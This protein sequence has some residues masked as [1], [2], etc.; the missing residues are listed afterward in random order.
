MADILPIAPHRQKAF[1]KVVVGGEDVTAKINER[2]LS[3][4]II[5]K[6]GGMDEC[7]LEL[8]DREGRIRLPAGPDEISV[9]L[10]WPNEGSFT[11]FKGK[12]ADLW[13][14]GQKHGGRTLTISAMGAD[15]QKDTKAP[16]Q[17]SL[18]DGQEDVKIGD[19]MKK[20][21]ELAGV[22]IKVS[23][24][25]A[26]LARKFWMGNNES[27]MAFA[28]RI[29]GEVGGSFKISGSQ[30]T[31]TKAGS[32]ANADGEPLFEV[33][34]KA[35]KN[36][37]AWRICPQDARPQ[38]GGTGHTFFNPVLAKW[39]KVT[40]AIKG[41]GL[42]G[43]AAS[44]M[45]TGLGALADKDVA[46]QQA[47]GD[48]TISLGMRGT[49]WVALDGEPRAVA[50]GKIMIIGARPGVDGDYHM[51]EVEH[52]MDAQTGFTTRCDVSKLGA[53]DSQEIK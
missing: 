38:W 17:W 39:E 21:G 37:L 28:Q 45:F 51:D 52:R 31:L 40:S 14:A 29:A 27:F 1:V 20:A 43:W 2:L 26:K 18:G 8:D 4:T 23:P 15:L 5:D 16:M 35:G 11:A 50:G 46:Q 24:D 41:G 48:R 3:L 47:D 9:E 19:A 10:G 6:L 36:L 42:P 25:L 49:G 7:H 32:F 22:N 34:A 12:T 53:V 13:S 44:A 33:S 30:A